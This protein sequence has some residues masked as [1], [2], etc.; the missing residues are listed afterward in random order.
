MGCQKSYNR[1]RT[2]NAMSK[3][4]TRQIKIY[5]ALHR[6]LSIKQYKP[7][8]IWGRGEECW[9][10]RR[11]G[12]ICSTSGTRRVVLVKILVVNGGK[13]FGL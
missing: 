3:K 5:Q 10:F 6:Q 4:A 7:H 11:V 2:D 12:N 1:G 9:C 8:K 13:E